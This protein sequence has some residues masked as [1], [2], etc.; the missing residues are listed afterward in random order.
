MYY[1][2]EL[3]LCFVIFFPLNFGGII[4][5]VQDLTLIICGKFDSLYLFGN[6]IFMLH[7]SILKF[8]T[9]VEEKTNISLFG[10]E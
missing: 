2:I 7:I 9:Y 3:Y 10:L 4:I 1:H 8:I 5:T 6:K